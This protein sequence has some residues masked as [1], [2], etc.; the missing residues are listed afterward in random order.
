MFDDVTDKLVGYYLLHFYW[1]IDTV[2]GCI[3]IDTH[4]LGLCRYLT[5]SGDL[6]DYEKKEVVCGKARAKNM[7]SV[8]AFEIFEV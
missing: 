8:L 4:W 5:V 6:G 1:A 3:Y 7:L 2:C